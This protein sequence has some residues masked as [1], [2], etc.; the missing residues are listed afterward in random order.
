MDHT[1]RYVSKNCHCLEEYFMEKDKRSQLAAMK[2][3]A[4]PLSESF[5][6]LDDLL[7]QRHAKPQGSD[8]GPS[9]RN[10]HEAIMNHLQGIVMK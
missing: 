8:R 3:C 1:A 2:P 4:M 6:C 10:S 9:P 5:H 7:V